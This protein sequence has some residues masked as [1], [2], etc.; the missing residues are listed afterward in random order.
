MNNPKLKG[1]LQEQGAAHLKSHLKIDEIAE[2]KQACKEHIYAQS[3]ENKKQLASIGS[4]ISINS[5]ADFT[6]TILHPG[7]LQTL[8][9]VGGNDIRFAGGYIVNKPAHSPASFWHQDWWCWQHPISYT[10]TLTQIGVLIYLDKTHPENGCLRIVPGSHQQKHA[11][12]DIVAK[13]SRKELREAKM[14]DTRPYDSHNS[15][16]AICSDPGDI[17]IIDPRVL[18][19]AYANKSGKNR[20]AIVLWYYPNF[21]DIPEEIR[22]SIIPADQKENVSQKLHPYMT[23]Y[24]GNLDPL[25]MA[26]N[27]QFP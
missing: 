1:T 18:H 16:Q 5:N 10:P 27:P 9:N 3:Y 13:Y 17:I 26:W 6:A 23:R 8:K 20:C 19:G 25:D 24:S 21:M 15:E 7:I 12:H 11:L 14:N 22:A 2:I 4:L